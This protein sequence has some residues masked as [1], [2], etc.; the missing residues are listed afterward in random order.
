MNQQILYLFKR[1][2]W[3]SLLA[4]LGYA[5]FL[6]LFASFI[7]QK[8]IP[9]LI[10][11]Q[12]HNYLR[13]KEAKQMSNVDLL[14]LG[15]S[16]AYRSFDTRIFTASN[17]KAF[18]LGSSSQTPKQT[19]ILLKRYLKQLNPK[20]VVFEV[21]PILFTSDGVESAIDLITSDNNDINSLKMVVDQ[22][23][24]KV[25]N[26]YLYAL[27]NSIFKKSPDI[28]LKTYHKGGYVSRANLKYYDGEKPIDEKIIIKEK[29]LKAFK[30]IIVMLESNNIDYILVQAP[31][32]QQ[33]YRSFTNM[34]EFNAKLKAYGD[35]YD[36]NNKLKLIDTLD[37]YDNHHLNQSGVTIFN[38]AFLELLEKEYN[39]IKGSLK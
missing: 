28:K 11:L 7:P 14:F 16:H 25:L 38:T 1:L 15:S 12:D 30:A 18:N 17:Y 3:F 10:Y 31:V 32:T 39:H 6:Y 9:N 21:N 29:Q 36:F 26:T 8:N 34:A 24:V 19:L 33:K 22:K 23:N 35:Y 5:V 20:L 27:A 13:L 2:I 4:F 37:F